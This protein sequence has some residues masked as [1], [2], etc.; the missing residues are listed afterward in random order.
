MQQQTKPCYT[1]RTQIPQLAERCPN[2]TTWV[3]YTGMPIRTANNH[4]A[5]QHASRGT[6]DSVG[7]GLGFWSLLLILL[8]VVGAFWDIWWPL[9][10]WF[11]AAAIQVVIWLRKG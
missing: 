5:N 8:Y 11:V 3:D 6:I 2:C 1:C 4:D 10:L 7:A 9:K